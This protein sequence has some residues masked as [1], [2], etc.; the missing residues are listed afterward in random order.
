MLHRARTAERP[1]RAILRVQHA[2]PRRACA[3]AAAGRHAA[4]FANSGQ[5]L[6]S[7]RVA[8]AVFMLLALGVF[9]LARR[10]QPCSVGDLGLPWRQRGVLALAAFVGAMLGAKL[11]FMLRSEAGSLTGPAWL[12]DGK[13]ITTGLIGGYIAVELAKWA[14]GLRVQ[15]GDTF[16][17]PLA[18]ALAV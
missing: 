6:M 7:P 5:P 10:L 1:C 16:A 9:V 11:P 17:L 3:A 15:T 12:A 8:Y 4:P 2:L 18:L 14:M 13:T